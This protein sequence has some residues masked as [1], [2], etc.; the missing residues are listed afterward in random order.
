MSQTI[1]MFCPGYCEPSYLESG[2]FAG[3]KAK[4]RLRSN[5]S[6]RIGR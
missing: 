6:N 3:V 2:G 4:T 5:R 1:T